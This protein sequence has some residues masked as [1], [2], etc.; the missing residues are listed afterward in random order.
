MHTGM[1]ELHASKPSLLLCINSLEG[2][3]SAKWGSYCA[4]FL[5]VIGELGGPAAHAG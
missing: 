2:A 1:K 4:E 3:R 5:E